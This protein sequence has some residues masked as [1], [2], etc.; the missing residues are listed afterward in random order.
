M[1]KPSP[2]GRTSRN[3]ARGVLSGLGGMRVIKGKVSSRFQI[4]GPNLKTAEDKIL[5][6]TGLASMAPGTLNVTIDSDYI[7]RGDVTIEP[8]EYFTG[9]RLKFQRCRV[10]GCRMFIMRPES[11]EHP[12][13]IGANVLELVSPMNLRDVWR[14][15]DG[16]PLEI[17]VEGDEQWWNQ[18]EPELIPVSPSEDAL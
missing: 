14:L 12:A 11:H 13:G 10:R 1:D 4:A 8:E 9:E 18:P 3:H 16:D 15:R 5:A 2:K 6:R 7:V 17:E